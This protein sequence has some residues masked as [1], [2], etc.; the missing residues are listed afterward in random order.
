MG[1]DRHAQQDRMFET[2]RV[3]KTQEM[4]VRG[5]SYLSPNSAG[6]L[7]IITGCRNPVMGTVLYSIFTVQTI[8]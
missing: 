7:C 8:Q 3:R 2:G 6:V 1:W 4:E 5:E